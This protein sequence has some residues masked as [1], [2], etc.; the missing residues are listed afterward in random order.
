[1]A[2]KLSET[3]TID[4]SIASND[5]FAVG[6]TSDSNNLKKASP[7][8]VLAGIGAMPTADGGVAALTEK[9]TLAV[10]D[11][12]LVEDSAASNAK[13]KV[14]A[15]N[16]WKLDPGSL[17]DHGFCGVQVVGT[18]GENLA[19]GDVCYLKSD[20]K[21]W[22]AQGDAAATMPAVAMATAAITADA[23]GVLLLDGY[24][25]NDDG[26]GGAL[27]VGSPALLYVSAATAGALTQT[28]PSG[29]GEFVQVIGY[30]HGARTVRFKP[31]LSILE[32]A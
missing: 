17:A 22:K 9:T 19:I 30:A 10:A 24:L 32:L 4:P 6:D 28:A 20:G 21:Y 8:Q 27:T 14:T 1:M 31:E 13:K 2:K 18:A 25:R 12:L 7:A 5:W 15:L 26:W 23:A 11:V 3:T 16:A 29:S